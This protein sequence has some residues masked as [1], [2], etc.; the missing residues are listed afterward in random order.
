MKKRIR[1][2]ESDLNRIVKGQMKKA[3]NEISYGTV[4]D[5]ADISRDTF[6]DL[7]R[8]Y[9]GV[10]NAIE[11]LDSAF[12]EFEPNLYQNRNFSL[13]GRKARENNPTMIEIYFLMSR[14][15]NNIET[16][17]DISSKLKSILERKEKQIN[18]FDDAVYKADSNP[19]LDWTEDYDNEEIRDLQNY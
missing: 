8:E 12:E 1:L 15:K 9:W 10:E 5:A 14:M 19:N 13:Y 16:L 6:S 11:E 3:I 4:K 2:T 7:I 17:T 18:N